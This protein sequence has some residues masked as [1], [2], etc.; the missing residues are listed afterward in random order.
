ML[1][2]ML[3]VEPYDKDSNVIEISV[4]SPFVQ[5]KNILCHFSSDESM[6]VALVFPTVDACCTVYSILMK[7]QVEVK[8]EVEDHSPTQQIRD[9]FFIPLLKAAK[10][11]PSFNE[12]AKNCIMDMLDHIAAVVAVQQDGILKS[13]LDEGF[14]EEVTAS[15]KESSN[16][17]MILDAIDFTQSTDEYQHEIKEKSGVSFNTQTN[18][19]M[20]E[21]PRPQAMERMQNCSLKRQKS[22]ETSVYPAITKQRKIEVLDDEQEDVSSLHPEP[23]QGAKIL[24]AKKIVKS[25]HFLIRKTINTGRKRHEL[26]LFLSD[27]KKLCYSYCFERKKR[28]NRFSCNGCRKMKHSAIAH[29]RCDEE[30]GEYF[31]ELGLIKHVCTPDIYANNRRLYIEPCTSYFSLFFE[32]ANVNIQTPFKG[33]FLTIMKVD[34]YSNTTA[35]KSSKSQTSIDQPSS[36]NSPESSTVVNATKQSAIVDAPK[37]VLK[38]PEFELQKISNIGLDFRYRLLVFASPDHKLCYVF[39]Q[40]DRNMSFSCRGCQDDRPSIM[41]TLHDNDD[42]EMCAYLNEHEHYCA[43]ELYSEV[44]QKPLMKDEYFIIYTRE[45]NMRPIIYDIS[46]KELCYAFSVK[47][48]SDQQIT[49][50]CDGCKYLHA[51]AAIDMRKKLDGEYELKWKRS[52]HTCEPKPFVNEVQEKILMADKYKLF[53]DSDTVTDLKLLTFPFDDDGDKCHIFKYSK[54]LK[55]FYCMKCLESDRVVIA[56]I[57][58]NSVQKKYILESSLAKHVCNALVYS[59]LDSSNFVIQASSGLEVKKFNEKVWN[60]NNLIIAENFEFQRNRQGTLNGYLMVSVSKERKS[61]YKYSHEKY[62]SRYLCQQC[63]A[64]AKVFTDEN[65]KCFIKLSTINHQCHRLIYK[66][67][68]K[69]IRKPDYI[70]FDKVKPFQLIVFTSP[71]HRE[72]Y[73]YSRKKFICLTC[74]S[75]RRDVSVYVT[76]FTDENG[77][78]CV[79]LGRQEHQCQPQKIEIVAEKYNIEL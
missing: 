32:T 65:G 39:C 30:S 18:G 26:I 79:Y 38:H 23:R 66:P 5:H 55:I 42:G 47:S 77:E 60:E 14:R 16:E 15:S 69:I 75:L 20:D 3:I 53:S 34:N 51:P 6:A 49:Y 52:V 73:V 71:S 58:V 40:L 9:L 61:C 64:S 59:T 37:K 45:G 36:S 19:V 22:S 43:P 48:C 44:S 33:K 54:A 50:I 68:R 29:L 8:Q 56:D 46:N 10:S 35:P 70:F 11:N 24:Q 21:E 78:E 25:T 28:G 31:V 1:S 27:E 74:H 2:E 63:Q 72:C 57:F 41:A 62:S 13:E 17:P 12:R 76:M 4:Y 7:Y 67:E